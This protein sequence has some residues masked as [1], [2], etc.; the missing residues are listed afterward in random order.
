MELTV[1]TYEV[2]D[3]VAAI[4]LNRPEAANAQSHKALEELDQ[5]WQEA[6]RDPAVKVIVLKSNGKHFS[7]G[8]DMSGSGKSSSAP[9]EYHADTLYDWETRTYLHYAKRWREVPKPSSPR[10]RANA[11]RAGSCCVGRAI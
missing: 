6:E 3:A 9:T 11:S 8:H 2:A 7:A 4:T 10:C 5:A 1:V